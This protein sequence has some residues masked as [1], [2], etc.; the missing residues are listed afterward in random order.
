MT[1]TSISKIQLLS[2]PQQPHNMQRFM[3]TPVTRVTLPSS[4]R[5]AQ[6]RRCLLH[7]ETRA[8]AGQPAISATLQPVS[9]TPETFAPFGQLI[10][11]THDGKEYDD[12]DA[13]LR[14]DA[15]TPR[16]YIMRL[17]RRGLSFDRIT[18]HAKVT[19][20]LVCT[21]WRCPECDQYSGLRSHHLNIKNNRVAWAP[22]IGTWQ[23]QN[24]HSLYNNTPPWMTWSCFASPRGCLSSWK[25]ARGMPA[26]CLMT[27]STWTFSI[28]SCQTPMSLITTHTCM[29][30]ALPL[31]WSRR[32]CGWQCVYVSVVQGTWRATI[33]KGLCVY[34]AV[35]LL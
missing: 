4:H 5:A 22:R 6:H 34:V 24:L 21:W 23:L 32:A 17:P 1:K 33:L 3:Q 27:L 18:Y 16:F 28:W 29:T 26:P 7:L 10:E 30:V 25:L 12:E 19:Q 11:P 14:L 31:Q 9:I 2:Q 35:F 15:G 8:A 20:C 13:Q